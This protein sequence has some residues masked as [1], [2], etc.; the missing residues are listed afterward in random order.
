MG[1]L[2]FSL[3]SLW[4]S[5]QVRRP[6]SEKVNKIIHPWNMG[7]KLTHGIERLPQGKDVDSVAI[8]AQRLCRL[9]T[10]TSNPDRPPQNLCSSP[11]I[12]DSLAVHAVHSGKGRGKLHRC[13]GIIR[14]AMPRRRHFNLPGSIGCALT[15]WRHSLIDASV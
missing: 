7:K 9:F 5:T 10:T 14:G 6:L 3:E 4:W 12:I 13:T 1:F 15:G 2:L 11:E 8:C